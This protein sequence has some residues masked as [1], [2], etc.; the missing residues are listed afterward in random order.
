M[1]ADSFASMTRATIE[2]SIVLTADAF[3]SM[4]ANKIVSLA[5]VCPTGFV[6]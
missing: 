6:Q 2:E 3:I 4:R 5:T 1:R